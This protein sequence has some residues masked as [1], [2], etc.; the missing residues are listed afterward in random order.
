[1]ITYNYMIY[2]NIIIY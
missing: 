1:M 2:D